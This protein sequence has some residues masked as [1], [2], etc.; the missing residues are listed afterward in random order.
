MNAIFNLPLYARIGLLLLALA[1][2]WLVFSGEHSSSQ[3]DLK[4][5]RSSDLAMT[6]FKMT[7]MDPEGKPVRIINGD[8]MEHFPESDTTEITNPIAE[9]LQTNRDSWI[10]TAN[11]GHTQ[12][13][14]TTIL[15]TGNVII[16]DKEN[17][18]LKMLTEKLT[19][20]TQYNTAYTDQ[21]VTIKSPNGDTESVGLHA[22]LNDET[23]NLHSRVKG[24]Y[25][26]PAN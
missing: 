15:L 20:D 21:A 13:K 23:I 1:S 2:I 14:G 22:D 17:P 7:I 11:H 18:A 6:D 24:Q 9:F 19:L 25:D 4:V 12:G 16:V 5:D 3:S 26:A 8:L 10:I